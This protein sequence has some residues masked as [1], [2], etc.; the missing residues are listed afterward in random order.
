MKCFHHII[1]QDRSFSVLTLHWNQSSA[2]ALIICPWNSWCHV[3]FHSCAW[4]SVLE[5]VKSSCWPQDVSYFDSWTGCRLS[6]LIKF[7]R[8][9]LFIDSFMIDIH[10]LKLPFGLSSPSCLCV[11]YVSGGFTA[12][13]YSCEALLRSQDTEAQLRL[14]FSINYIFLKK[15]SPEDRSEWMLTDPIRH[16]YML[17]DWVQKSQNHRLV[18]VRRGLKAPSSLLP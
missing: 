15:H 17:S 13:D 5:L 3:L 11:V 18:W 14:L 16:P 4:I 10:L 9:V 7:C 8:S 12:S 2:C 6:F 1:C